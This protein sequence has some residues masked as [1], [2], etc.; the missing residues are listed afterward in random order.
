MGDNKTIPVD[1]RVVAATNLDLEKEVDDGRFHKD[2]Y[3]RLRGFE[4]SVPPLRERPNDI[5]PLAEYFLGK[6]ALACGQKI[7]DRIGLSKKAREKL[8]S[9]KWEGNIGELEK[10]MERAVIVCGGKVIRANNLNLRSLDTTDIDE[11]CTDTDDRPDSG[12]PEFIRLKAIKQGYEAESAELMHILTPTGG[13]IKKAQ[14]ELYKKMHGGKEPPASYSSNSL[15]Q[16][17]SKFKTDLQELHTKHPF[18]DFQAIL[19]TFEQ[20]LNEL[21]D[22]KKKVNAIVPKKRSSSAEIDGKVKKAIEMKLYNN[23]M[24]KTQLE[25]AVGLPEA[26]LSRG[27]AKEQ[28]D[29]LTSTIA[30]QRDKDGRIANSD[31]DPDFDLD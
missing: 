20:K 17:C 18:F 27:E 19:D 31:S 29:R 21:R 6:V 13:N 10:A 16:R 7:D 3:F 1:V 12:S 15:Q 9:H 25:R 14:R 8:I 30:I 28:F 22:S 5:I 23:D 24:T 2:L 4:I 26:T 11:S